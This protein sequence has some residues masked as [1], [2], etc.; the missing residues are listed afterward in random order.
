MGVKQDMEESLK[1]FEV[2]KIDGQPNDE[3]LN[4]LKTNFAQL[5]QVFPLQRGEESMAML[6]WSVVWCNL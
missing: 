4:Q 1:D 2:I 6:G 5:Q 3:D